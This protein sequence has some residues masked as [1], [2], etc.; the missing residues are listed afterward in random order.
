[1]SIPQVACYALILQ[2]IADLLGTDIEVKSLIFNSEGAWE[3]EPGNTL[4]E[5]DKLME[6]KVPSFVPPWLDFSLTGLY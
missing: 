3:F 1:M 5:V 2:V 6:E 4:R